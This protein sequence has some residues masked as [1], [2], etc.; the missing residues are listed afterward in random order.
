MVSPYP[1]HDTGLIS[2]ETNQAIDFV[3]AV[4][5]SIRNIRQQYTVS[6][7]TPVAATI[8]APEATEKA[9]HRSRQRHPKPLRQTLRPDGGRKTHRKTR[10]SRRQRGGQQPNPHPTG[11]THRH[12]SRNLS[13]SPK[14]QRHSPKNKPN[15]TACSI[16]KALWTK[17]PRPSSPKTAPASPKSKPNSPPSKNNWLA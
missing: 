3:L 4:V 2:E 1:V 17:P 11:R 8:E 6:H 12:R 16:T 15:S 5:R 9:A 14:K 13:A 10:P 7:A